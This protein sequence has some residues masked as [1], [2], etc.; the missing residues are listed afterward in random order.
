MTDALVGLPPMVVAGLLG[1]HPDPA[2]RGATLVGGDRS[3]CWAVLRA[4]P[5]G[6][7][8]RAHGFSVRPQVGVA[9]S[10]ECHGQGAPPPVGV[11]L[12]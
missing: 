8:G 10:G 12:P 9:E 7:P 1:I 5:R 6:R 11:V 4:A 3:A 2:E